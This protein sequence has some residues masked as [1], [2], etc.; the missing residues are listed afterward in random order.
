MCSNDNGIYEKTSCYGEVGRQSTV[1][2]W[3]NTQKLEVTK[4]EV[5][6]LWSDN[7]AA[8]LQVAVIPK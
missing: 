1:C 7:G 8:A 3:F 5:L 6:G 2:T 4:V